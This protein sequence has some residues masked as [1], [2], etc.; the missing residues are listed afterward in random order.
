[1]NY[2]LTTRLSQRLMSSKTRFLGDGI[3]AVR[4]AGGSLVLMSALR[5]PLGATISGKSSASSS[6]IA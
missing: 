1:M 5:A 4:L 3:G 2:P 6:K